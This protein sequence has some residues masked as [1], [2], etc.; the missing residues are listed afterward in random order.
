MELARKKC[1][2]LAGSFKR[3]SVYPSKWLFWGKFWYGL[4]SRYRKCRVSKFL[5]EILGP[6]YRR[7]RNFIEIDITYLCNLHCLNCN[8]SASQAPQTLHIS[9]KRIEDFVDESIACKHRWDRIRVLGGEPTLHPQFHEIIERLLRYHKWNPGCL[10]EVVTNGYGEKVRS[11]LALLPK[12]IW[13]ENSRKTGQVQSTFGPFNLAPCDDPSFS[14]ADYRNGC[15]IMEECGM[16]LTPMGYYPCAIAGGID[17]IA[18]WGVGYNKLPASED[19]MLELVDRCCTFCGRFQSGHFI[20]K[21]LRPNLL[22]TKMSASWLNLYRN[23]EET[24]KIS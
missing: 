24:R 14:G 23:W 20:P 7:S 2:R 12:D 18:G 1:D 9:M 3:S 19:D 13:I 16:G 8:R 10:I 15:A 4:R 5:T 22:E 6:Q 11:V 17:R 21:N